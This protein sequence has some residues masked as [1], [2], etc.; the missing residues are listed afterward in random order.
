[1]R[2]LPHPARISRPRRISRLLAL[3]VLALL[4]SVLAVPS[5]GTGTADSPGHPREDARPQAATT[6]PD[7]TAAPRGYSYGPHPRQRLLA[8]A[9]GGRPDPGHRTAVLVLH[10]GYWSMERSRHWTVWSSRFARAGFVVF[11]IDYRRNVDAP[12]P[13]PRDDVRRAVA[14]VRARADRFGVDPRRVF[15]VG[16]SAGGHLALSA[17]L[18]GHGRQRVAG[19]VGLSAIS[20]PLRSWRDAADGGTPGRRRLHAGARALADC[21][22]AACPWVWADM[23]PAR[24][25]SG[26]DDPP[27]LLVHS[28]H[29]FVP[30]AHARALTRALRAAGAPPRDTTVVTV[31]GHA[32]GGPLLDRPDAFTHIVTWLRR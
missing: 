2:P 13:G 31:P 20:D 27:V 25:A 18:L 19:I 29:D 23:T 4:S 7:G 8:F 17:G 1:M 9:P 30:A 12:W 21:G 16:S 14:W 15:L 32:H 22:P 10:G 26:R 5:P 11:D 28:R 24:H 3:T 6:G